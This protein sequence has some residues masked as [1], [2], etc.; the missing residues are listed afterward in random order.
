LEGIRF[1]GNLVNGSTLIGLALAGI[2]GA[3][4]S[5]DE[6]GL[7]LAGEY[8][9]HFPRA[10]AFTIGCVIL[11]TARWAELQ[12]RR[13]GLLRHEGRHSWQ[14]FCLAGVPF[15][16]LYS[17]AIAY[18]WLRSG[19]LAAHNVFERWAGLELGGYREVEARN[20]GL[21]RLLRRYY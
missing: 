4:L 13:P 10:G 16:P 5:W 15:F 8:R 12:Q 19:D 3:K 11:S 17:L 20:Q 9:F 2:G 14:Y 18:S 21:R 6:S 7:I 1:L